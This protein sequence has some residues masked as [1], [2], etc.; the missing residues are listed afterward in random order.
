MGEG[1][2]RIIK[3]FVS[4]PPRACLIK[5]ESKALVS[6]GVFCVLI[7]RIL[8]KVYSVIVSTAHQI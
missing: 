1:N 6:T 5:V 4:I 8:G 3:S 7:S 2:K